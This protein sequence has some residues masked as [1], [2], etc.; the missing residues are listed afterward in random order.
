MKPLIVAKL[1]TLLALLALLLLSYRPFELGLGLL[2][3]AANRRRIDKLRFLVTDLARR[4]W[5]MEWTAAWCEVLL[6]MLVGEGE[7]DSVKDSP[8]FVTPWRSMMILLQRQCIDIRLWKLDVRLNDREA[9][10]T[11]RTIE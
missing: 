9:M 4:L 10:E 5:R 1:P 11:G 3:D 2:F 7:E 8:R 6:F